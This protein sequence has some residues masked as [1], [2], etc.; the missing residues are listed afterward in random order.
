[1]IIRNKVAYYHHIRYPWNMTYFTRTLDF[2]RDLKRKSVFLF[3][4]RQTGKTSYL[5]KRFPKAPF[6][7]LLLADTFATLSQRP[8]LIREE[9]LALKGNIP[10]PIIIDEIQ[11]LP[12]LLDEVQNL[13]EEKKCHFILTG[14]SA[15]KL[16]RGGVNLLGG[17]ARTKHLYP[18]TSA[19]IPNYDLLRILNVGSL[20]A[21]YLS[22]EPE[23]DLGDYVGTYLQEE[24]KAESLTRR[25]EHF[26][27]F[28]QT[29]SLANAELVNFTNVGNDAGVPPRTAAQYFEILEDTMIGSLLPPFTKTK[30]RKAISTAKFYF[31]DVGV[32]NHLAG[33]QNI[34]PKTELFGKV[35][36][37]FVFTELTAY[38]S[39]REDARPLSFWRSTSGYEVDFLLADEIAIE[40]KGTEMA[41]ER[42]AKGLRALSEDLPLKKQILVTN[43]PRPRKMGDV[44][45][46]PIR[47]FLEQ[48]WAGDI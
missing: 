32:C 29:A 22:E 6:Y 42:H 36:E 37:H 24:I 47:L 3:G 25:I 45:V 9:L 19:E 23:K 34:R 13:I 38:R 46:L 30:K 48:L 39:Y 14:S 1:M 16:K 41:N 10:S 15:R 35:L 4:P 11:K 7:N 43:D 5:K 20:P 17:R 8:Q 26:S 31:F 28:L 21:I 27:R 2:D 18:L 12:L 44:D 33:R 40:V